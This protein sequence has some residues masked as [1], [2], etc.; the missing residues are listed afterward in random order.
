M[1]AFSEFM[2][3]WE[4]LAPKASLM[5]QSFP[6]LCKQYAFACRARTIPDGF[7]RLQKANPRYLAPSTTTTSICGQIRAQSSYLKQL[8]TSATLPPFESR[9]PVAEHLPQRSN[10][11]ARNLPQCGSLYPRVQA[12]AHWCVM[13]S[14]SLPGRSPSMMG[15][16]P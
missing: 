11:I 12:Q 7:S 15:L 13:R 16:V 6:I 5:R 2:L 4:H 3:T 14:R 9:P 8:P 1:N 10:F